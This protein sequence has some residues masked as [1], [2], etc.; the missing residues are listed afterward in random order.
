[1]VQKLYITTGLDNKRTIANCIL[2]N[3]VGRCKNF[4]VTFISFH[5]SKKQ[6]PVHFTKF[7]NIAFISEKTV[8]VTPVG[9]VMSGTSL[10]KDFN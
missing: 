9:N 3:L 6:L 7:Y 5:F 4:I 2:V 8:M 1:M 10:C